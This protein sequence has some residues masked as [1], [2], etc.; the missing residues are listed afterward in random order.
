MEWQRPSDSTPRCGGGDRDG[1]ARPHE[2]V[3]QVG[4]REG[5]F[6]SGGQ[7]VVEAQRDGFGELAQLV[8]DDG[9]VGVGG[10]VGEAVVNVGGVHRFR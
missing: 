4:Y 8:V 9:G 7:Q 2:G 5:L 1:F 6:A 3:F 10:V